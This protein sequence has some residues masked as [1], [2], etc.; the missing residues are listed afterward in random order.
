MY[1]YIRK[2]SNTIIVL[3]F[4]YLIFLTISL[5][6]LTIVAAKGSLTPIILYLLM[7]FLGIGLI[8]LF[9]N[10]NDYLLKIKLFIFFFSLYLIYTLVNHTILIGFFPEYLPFNYTDEQLFYHASS[11]GLP[12]VSGEKYFFD[13]F[14]VFEIHELPLHVVFSA[15]IT[16]LSMIIDGGNTIIV[17][18]LLSPFLGSLFIVVLYSTLKHQFRELFFALNATMMYGLFSAIF[19]YSTPLL[20]DIDIALAYMIFI[21]LFLQKNSYKNFFLLL[22]VAFCTVY[23][24]VESGLVLFGTTFLYSYLY[25]KNLENKSIK[26]IFYILVMVLFSI[27]FALVFHKITSMIVD[28]DTSNT[29]RATARSS[30][31]SIILSLKKLPF[32]I[33]Y[34]PMVLFGQMQPFPIFLSIERPLEVISGF[35]WPFIFVMMTYAIIIKDIRVE[36]DI[37]MKYLLVIA[38]IVLFLM[39]S[40]ANVRRMMSVYPIIY[41]MALYSFNF[42]NKRKI[43]QFFYFYVFVM[44]I[45]NML[46]YSMKI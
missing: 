9:S 44:V 29:L 7:L 46:Y 23:L 36:I 21:Y 1:T 10:K 35:L 24:R 32:G 4:G 28:L 6:F 16:Y 34:I 18:K 15:A 42:L 40:E 26:L 22:L 2:K 33:G 39:A 14:S 20:R 37:K 11:L 8:S 38:I 13:L 3:N 31:S 5:L 12:Y 41:I 19:M 25:V 30:G 17:Q 43:K 45:L 27:I